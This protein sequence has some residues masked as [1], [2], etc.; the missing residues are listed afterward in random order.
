ML[1]PFSFMDSVFRLFSFSAEKS[2]SEK[3]KAGADLIDILEKIFYKNTV[4]FEENLLARL[5][6]KS[7]F[8]LLSVNHSLNEKVNQSKAYQQAKLVAL[9]WREAQRV[10]E[11]LEP[12]NDGRELLYIAIANQKA[13]ENPA[14]GIDYLKKTLKT[15]GSKGSEDIERTIDEWMIK[16]DPA[17]GL[18]CASSFPRILE[19]AKKFVCMKM[20]ENADKAVMKALLAVERLSPE[21]HI[22]AL[23]DLARANLPLNQEHLALAE[24]NVR[25]IR[26]EYHRAHALVTLA[27]LYKKMPGYSQDASLIL[28][29]AEKMADRFKERQS[30]YCE[31]ASAWADLDVKEA[32]RILKKIDKSTSPDTALL[33]VVKALAERK[34]FNEALAYAQRM[35]V[36][37]L[38]SEALMIIVLSQA[39]T[40]PETA[41]KIV[42]SFPHAKK[43][44]RYEA[45]AEII[46][47]VAKSDPQKAVGIFDRLKKEQPDL[48][49]VLVDTSSFDRLIM[50]ILSHGRDR[51]LEM[52]HLLP[53]TNPLYARILSKMA[54]G[55]AALDRKAAKEL[56]LQAT[57]SLKFN[58]MQTNARVFE[59]IASV[60]SDIGEVREAA[61]AVITALDSVRSLKD[62]DKARHGLGLARMA[63]RLDRGEIKLDTSGY[64]HVLT[65]S[66]VFKNRHAN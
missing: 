15:F 29:E 61:S 12:Y 14:S 56:L 39:K 1:L 11:G 43:V 20:P 21:K 31:T 24:Q 28:R 42:C 53:S 37:E 6:F 26:E 16:K 50:A 63:K 36:S 4:I 32:L 8:C 38:T 64:Q 18:K 17:E 41:L 62:S 60:Y 3:A 19:I 10:A 9:L 58:R 5:D 13:Q 47:L 59:R 2:P 51:S 22:P 65:E 54:R 34:E 52:A 27:N 55:L 48:C 23:M 40:E 35:R 25:S 57:T 45:L 33:P 7:V 30:L 44:S 46:S 66:K 49:K